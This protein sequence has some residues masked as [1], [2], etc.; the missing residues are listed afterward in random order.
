MG[1]KNVV[2]L[3]NCVG[4]RASRESD[5]PLP[6]IIDS[7]HYGAL[8]PVMMDNFVLRVATILSLLYACTCW[9]P[10]EFMLMKFDICTIDLYCY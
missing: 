10:H 5:N 4:E 6:F 1:M 8:R 7:I 9:E 3:S 2:Y